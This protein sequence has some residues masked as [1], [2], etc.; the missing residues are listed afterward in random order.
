MKKAIALAALALAVVLMPGGCVV[1]LAVAGGVITAAAPTPSCLST[2]GETTDNCSLASAPASTSTWVDPASIVAPDPAAGI[3]VAAA[4]TAVGRG[5]RYVAEG[6]GP[7]D[8]DCSGLTAWAWRQAGVALV[9]YSYSQRSQTRD[10]PRAL[11]QPGDLVFWFGGSEHH[12]AIITAVS[13]SQ[14]TIAE[15]ANPTAG[16][17]VRQLGGSWDDAYLTGFGRVVRP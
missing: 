2:D 13:S 1:T 15:A 11:A 16:I 3:A 10:I 12:V 7:V 14:V 9:D 6:N 4:L 8:F 17:R 5:G